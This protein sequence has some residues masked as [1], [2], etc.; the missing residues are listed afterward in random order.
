MTRIYQSA[1]GELVDVDAVYI[2]QQM[3]LVPMEVDVARRKNFIDAK[4]GKPSLQQKAFLP[5]LG[6]FDNSVVPVEDVPAVEP[7]VIAPT[8]KGKK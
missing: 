4:E 1:R 6:S 3:S 5:E 7:V 8:T 2:K